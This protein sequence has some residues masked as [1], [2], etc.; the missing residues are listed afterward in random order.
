MA[1]FLLAYIEVK[2]P[3]E[4][5]EYIRQVPPLVA[6]HGGVYRARGG[7]CT[8]QEGSWQPRRTVLLEFPDRQSAE[9]FYFDPEYK[10]VKAIRLRT[11][12]TNL[13]LFDGL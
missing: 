8:V 1:A 10:D 9:A 4:Y 5:Q 2:D 13:I 12:D 11:A 7:E 3:E 6:K